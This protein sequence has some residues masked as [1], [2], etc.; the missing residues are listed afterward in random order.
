MVL[1]NHRRTHKPSQL[2]RINDFNISHGEIEKKTMRQ[3]EKHCFIF[4]LKGYET[5]DL[6]SDIKFYFYCR[7]T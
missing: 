7:L 1:E 3:L 6:F 4:L 5:N 2:V